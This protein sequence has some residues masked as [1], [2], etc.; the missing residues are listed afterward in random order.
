MDLQTQ[1]PN[2]IPACNLAEQPPASAP[3]RHRPKPP[4]PVHS[5]QISRNPHLDRRA[6]ISPPA[7]QAPQSAPHS[8]PMSQRAAFAPAAPVGLARAARRDL[9][10]RLRRAR[11]VPTRRGARMCE[12]EPATAATEPVED[13]R[14]DKQKEIDRL[15]AAEKFITVDEGTY[16]CMSCGY[17]YEPLKGERMNGVPQ[18]T[19]F[20]KVPDDFAC[21][22]CR[23]GKKGFSSKKKVIAG[24]ADN[25]KYGFGSNSMTAGQKNLLIFG[26]LAF[27]FV[28]LLSGYALN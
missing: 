10:G 19:E 28:L 16:E 6:R 3:K 14:T 11:P 24:F 5:A 1:I 17:M 7:P 2:W 9:C 25:Q 22:V 12:Q 13:D 23:T 8:R 15:R 21:P 18:G 26:G 4:P 20:A 27:F